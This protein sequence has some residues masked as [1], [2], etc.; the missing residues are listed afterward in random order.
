MGT[1][2]RSLIIGAAVIVLLSGAVVALADTGTEKSVVTPSEQPITANENTNAVSITAPAAVLIDANTG[3]VLYA[4]NVLQKHYPASLTKLMT[5]V[6]ALDLV[7]RGQLTLQSIIPVSQS[8][9]KVAQTPGL[10]VAYL[11]PAEH[12]TLARMLQYMFIVSADDAAVAVADSIAGSQTEFAKLMNEKAQ[13]LGLTGTHYTNASGLQNRDMYTNAWD[14]AILS[15]YL[16]ENDPIVLKYASEPGMYIHPG[17]YGPNYDQLLGQFNGLDGL[18]TGSTN[19]AGYCFSGTAIRGKTRLIS[20]VLDTNSFS[21]VFQ[22]TASLLG[23]GFSQFSSKLFQSAGQPLTTQLQVVD[24]ANSELS[25]A[26]KKDVYVDVQKGSKQ[27]IS[28]TM[29]PDVLSA[30]IVVGQKVATENIVINDHI[31]QQVPLYALKSDPKAD[32]IQ[33][34]W[35]T[36]LASAHQGARHIVKWVGSKVHKYV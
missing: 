8:A 16:V 25:V 23:Y 9:Y 32:L 26:P 33:K 30:P 24:A 5:S 17:Q 19:E 1:V 6:I 31:V 7:K 35:R 36:V 2:K 34:L 28:Y 22:D 20:V 29:T 14:V 15:R 27:T 12:I 4:K 18:K 11:N 13:A 3:Q 21:D 10:S